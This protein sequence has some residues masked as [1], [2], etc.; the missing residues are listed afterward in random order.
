M[1]SKIDNAVLIELRLL[2]RFLR[3]I[4]SKLEV[5]LADLQ[6]LSNRLNFRAGSGQLCQAFRKRLN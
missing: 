5:T 2:D 3:R 4:Q 1:G 6:A